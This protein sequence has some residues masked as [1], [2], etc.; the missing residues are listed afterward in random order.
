M[1]MITVMDCFQLLYGCMGC[2]YMGWHGF[3][4]VWFVY[5]SDKPFVNVCQRNTVVLNTSCCSILHSQI[6]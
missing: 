1:F 2:M 6:Y 3:I 4:T 5:Y